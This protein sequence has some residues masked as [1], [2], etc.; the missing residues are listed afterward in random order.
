MKNKLMMMLI[1]ALAA[2][3]TAAAAHADFSLGGGFGDMASDAQHSVEQQLNNAA[4]A[5]NN[6]GYFS[7]D[8]ADFGVVQV[9]NLGLVFY[10]KLAGS[11]TWN[12]L[13]TRYMNEVITVC[14]Q[15]TKHCTDYKFEN[16]KI[17]VVL[18][19]QSPPYTHPAPQ[20]DGGDCWVV[21]DD[22]GQAVVGLWSGNFGLGYSYDCS[23]NTTASNSPKP[24]TIPVYVPFS[25]CRPFWDKQKFTCT[26]ESKFLPDIQQLRD[27]NYYNARISFI[28]G[29]DWVTG[30]HYGEKHEMLEQYPQS[31]ILSLNDLLT[32]TKDGDGDTIPDAW[33]NCAEVANNQMMPPKYDDY[34][35]QQDSDFD[36]VG[37]ACD[38]CN[39]LWDPTNQCVPPPQMP[40]TEDEATKKLYF[41]Q[42]EKDYG[43]VIT[44]DK[45]VFF[46][47]F[48]A[49]KQLSD[50]PEVAGK[51]IGVFSAWND[52]NGNYREHCS[53]PAL[54]WKNE[55]GDLDWVDNPI[56]LSCLGIK[57]DKGVMCT[58]PLD[59][60]AQSFEISVDE[61]KAA[62]E[63]HDDNLRFFFGGGL[64]YALPSYKSP[65][66]TIKAL[67]EA[68][69]KS[70]DKDDDGIPDKWDDSIDD[71]G[72]TSSPS[73]PDDSAT[74]QG[75]SA[76]DS[77]ETGDN[78]DDKDGDGI[79]DD[80]D[81][82]QEDAGSFSFDPAKNGCPGAN[83]NASETS[84]SAD[85]GG[86][87]LAPTATID[88]A[89]LVLIAAALAPIILRRKP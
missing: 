60:V 17:A 54:D 81:A 31:M 8:P 23:S 40:K 13:P 37:D 36:G 7:K 76:D 56:K 77:D 67:R 29:P 6:I 46:A 64:E 5:V 61:F 58:A 24:Y 55:N 73:D 52:E 66:V 63:A 45:V 62:F 21:Q 72:K 47:M 53:F 9:K 80:A 75:V 2:T 15:D 88:P 38:K 20:S 65:F 22:K 50:F 89:A 70:K 26:I 19:L 68:A 74:P 41:S 71:P 32:T 69:E 85:N 84:G 27:P 51:R 48:G 18:Y 4:E 39:D 14:N 86:C 42:K 3:L 34:W 87:T 12:D 1:A 57:K 83:L 11:N 25:D 78:M 79:S 59:Q 10:G 82:C 28:S 30:T 49:T 16:P 43:I 35:H 44:G 33:D